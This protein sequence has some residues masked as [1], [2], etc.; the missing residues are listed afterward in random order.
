M[1][2]TTQTEKRHQKTPSARVRI[3]PQSLLRGEYIPLGKACELLG[4]ID[5]RTLRGWIDELRIKTF[6]HP[7]DG[8]ISLLRSTD[9]AKLAKISDRPVMLPATTRT[10]LT[11]RAA[12]ERQL[13]DLQLEH[14]RTIADYE[15]QLADLREQHERELEAL[16]RRIPA[17]E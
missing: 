12:L 6:A 11:P 13:A 15:R 17:Q 5:T 9:V 4:G 8:R 16:R 1:K 3:T 14:E 2:R 7:T 10:R